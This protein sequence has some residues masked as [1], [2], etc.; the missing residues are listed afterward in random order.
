[1][2]AGAVRWSCTRCK[3]SVGRLDGSPS[4]LPTTWTRIGD[5]TFCLTCSRALVGEAAMD[6]APSACSRQERF[7]LRSEAVIRFEI[8]RTP[9]AADR[10][11]AHA[12]RT[13][14]RKVAS[15]RAALADVGS[16]QPTAPSGG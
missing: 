10:I 13:S 11:I 3:V 12:C 5:S 9:L 8:D 14:P 2:G 1:M 4:R 15:V 7:L 16:Q 6:S